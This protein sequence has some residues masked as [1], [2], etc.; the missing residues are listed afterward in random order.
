[1]GQAA[2]HN[3]HASSDLRRKSLTVLTAVT[4]LLAVGLTIGALVA[5]EGVRTLAKIVLGPAD[6]SVNWTQFGFDGQ[7]TRDN[8]AETRINANNVAGLHLA[9]RTKLPAIADST[10]ALLHGLTFPDGT[11]HDVLYLTTRS[12]GLVALDS[13]SGA[14]LWTQSYTVSDPNKFTTSS[15]YADAAS[16]TVFSYGMDGR[17]HKYDAVT[18]KELRGG[19]WPVKVTT[20]PLS[21]KESSALNA[22]NGYLYVATASFG[23]DAPPYQGHVVA[24]NLSDGTAHVFNSICSDRTHLLAPG[25]CRVNG[26]GIWARPGVVVDQHTGDLWL[27]TANGPYT[28]DT[29][30]HDWGDSVLRLSPDGTHVLDSYTPKQQDDLYTQ[31]L[32]LG[33]TAPALLPDIPSSSTPHLLVQAGKDSVLRL[34]NRQDLSGQGGPGHVGGELQTID[35]PGHC[36]TLAQPAVWSDPKTGTAWVFVASTCAIGGYQVHASPAGRALLRLA[37]TVPVAATSPIIA[38]G[39]LFAATTGAKAI[40]ALDPYTGRQLWNSHSSNAGGTIGYTHWENPIVVNGQLDC[41]DEN[42]DVV[43]YRP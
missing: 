1:L 10:P 12:G 38:G 43:A 29:G 2:R 23:G 20:M 28:A 8:T 5:P 26:S 11:Q 22:A 37:W 39:V 24:I 25:E 7:G 40:L 21:E 32:D 31:D 9:W 4:G 13:D 30:G 35:A 41:T 18:G 15:P 36:P 34:L 33:S 16:I 14:V 42:G 27:A 3:L 6:T 17:V 19:G